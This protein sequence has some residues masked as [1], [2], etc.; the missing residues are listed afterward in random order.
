MNV[1]NCPKHAQYLDISRYIKTIIPEKSLCKKWRSPPKE[2]KSSRYRV[3]FQCGIMMTL[4]GVVD[5][6]LDKS[7]T[8]GYQIFFRDEQDYMMVVLRGV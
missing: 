8:N 2:Y 3:W 4:D 6:K 7:I 1:L 5:S